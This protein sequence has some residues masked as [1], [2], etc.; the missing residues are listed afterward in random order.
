[1]E[2]QRNIQGKSKEPIKEHLKRIP[3][4]LMR[5]VWLRKYKKTNSC[6]RNRKMATK[7]KLK[8]IVRITIR[9]RIKQRMMVMMIRS[10]KIHENLN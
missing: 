4:K 5:M 1:M 2:A 8:L 9:K 10:R 6:R 7:R 3:I